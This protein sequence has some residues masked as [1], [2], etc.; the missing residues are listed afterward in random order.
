MVIQLP[1]F[2]FCVCLKNRAT[3]SHCVYASLSGVCVNNVNFHSVLVTKVVLKGSV[4]GGTSLEFERFLFSLCGCQLW[5]ILW[6]WRLQRDS[7]LPK[8]LLCQVPSP[9]V[10]SHPLFSRSP[11]LLLQFQPLSFISHLLLSQF[12]P[13]CN[14]IPPSLLSL[15]AYLLVHIS[16]TSPYCINRDLKSWVYKL[17]IVVR[18]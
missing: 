5:W 9:S 13:Y 1:V 14:L 15:L 8:F 7:E 6:I 11:P 3:W 10:N 16:V 12:I 2:S 4:I 18:Y 17:V